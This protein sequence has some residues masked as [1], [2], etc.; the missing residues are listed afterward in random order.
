ME[1]RNVHSLLDVASLILEKGLEHVEVEVI[2]KDFLIHCFVLFA[3]K[4]LVLVVPTHVDVEIGGLEALKLCEVL[5]LGLAFVLMNLFAGGHIPC[6][7]N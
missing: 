4:Q 6:Y 3:D 1:V 5:L 7:Q 2:L